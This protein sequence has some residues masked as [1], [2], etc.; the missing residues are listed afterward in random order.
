MQ[1]APTADVLGYR[2]HEQA[3]AEYHHDIRHYRQISPSL[4]AAFVAEVEAAIERIRHSPQAHS[5]I[6]DNLRRCLVRRFRHAV[7]YE[8]H[9]DGIFIWA[10]MHTSREPGYWKER[11]KE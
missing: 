3:A 11:T 5:P 10:V 8:I 1:K 9:P 2:Y 4:G 7:I 6:G